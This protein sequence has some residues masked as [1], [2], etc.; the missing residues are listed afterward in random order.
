MNGAE[1]KC[2]VLVTEGENKASL[3]VTRS[4]GRYGCKVIVTGERERNLASRSRYCTARYTVPSPLSDNEGYLRAM[5]DIVSSQNVD[6]LFPMTEPAT[7]LLA[8]NR[9]KLPRYTILACPDFAKI[10]TVFDKSAVFRLA[11]EKGVAI[12]W[13][14]FVDNCKDFQKKKQIVQRFPV[15]VKTSRSRIPVK[16]GFLASGVMYAEDMAA[17][18]NLYQTEQSLNFPSMIQEKIIGPGTGLFTLFEDDHHLALFSHQR[19]LEKPPSGGVSVVCESVHL[20]QEM[21]EASRKLLA[22]VG[23]RGVAMVEFKRD[24]CDGRAKLMEINGRFWGSLQLAIASGIDFPVLFLRQLTQGGQGEAP[25]DSYQ[26]GLRM[27]WL[28]GTLDYLLIRLLHRDS[29]LNLPQGSPGKI[30]SIMNF[31]KIKEKNTVF[32]VLDRK[33]LGPFYYEVQNYLLYLISRIIQKYLKKF[34]RIN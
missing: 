25:E 1:K 2:T 12:P 8:K 4:L 15:V 11:G 26:V 6:V 3:A 13:T 5:L 14:L 29:T 31:L 28:L 17:L 27:K 30:R 7:L 9:Q 22:A 19:I 23:W 34:K 24:I 32:D 20:D 21:V 10:Q 18:E 16:D 33:D